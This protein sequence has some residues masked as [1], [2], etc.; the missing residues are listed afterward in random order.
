LHAI[1]V[2]SY[3]GSKTNNALPGRARAKGPIEAIGK[4]GTEH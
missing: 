3:P 2:L 4:Q 1:L